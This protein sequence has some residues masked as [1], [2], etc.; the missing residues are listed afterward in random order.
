MVYVNSIFG[1]VFNSKETFTE[2]EVD[3]IKEVLTKAGYYLVDR[4]NFHVNN[5]SICEA[6]I[7]GRFPS[8][9]NL[10]E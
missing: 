5:N 10:I 2:R 7:P 1:A 4:E 6:S 3:K 9:L 8:N